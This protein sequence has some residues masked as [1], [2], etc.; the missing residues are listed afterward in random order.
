MRLGIVESLGLVA[1]LVFAV[2]AGIAGV[3]LLQDGRIALGATLVV[4]ALLMV[5]VPRYVVAPQDLPGELAARLAGRAT[6]D[7]DAAG[8]REEGDRRERGG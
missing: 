8:D 1:S 2:P 6:R 3:E 5:V 7:P 4:V